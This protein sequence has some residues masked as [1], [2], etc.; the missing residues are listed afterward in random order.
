[1]VEGWGAILLACTCECRRQGSGE[2]AGPEREEKVW[3]EVTSSAQKQAPSQALFLFGDVDTALSGRRTPHGV[4]RAS[5]LPE[6]PST[7]R[8]RCA[9]EVSS[10]AALIG[11]GG[12]GWWRRMGV[13]AGHGCGVVGV[14]GFLGLL[15]ICTVIFLLFPLVSR[16]TLPE[17]YPS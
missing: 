7:S 2:M 6:T 14:Q 13:W 11:P 4:A 17:R 1:M 9:R 3:L 12:Q 10:S 5:Q 15:P 8:F 16:N